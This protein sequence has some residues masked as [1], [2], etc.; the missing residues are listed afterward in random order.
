MSEKL[1]QAIQATRV[2]DKKN[3]QFLLTQAIQEEPDNPQSWYL[4]SLLVDDNEKQQVYLTKVLDLD[5]DHIKAHEKL[6]AISQTAVIKPALIP[7]T[8]E[9]EEE[10]IEIAPVI[11]SSNSGDLE[12]QDDGETL[13]DWMADDLPDLA[14]KTTTTVVETAVISET[15]VPDWLQ[16][17]VDETWAENETETAVAETNQPEIK[18]APKPAEENKL[19]I[20]EKKTA[21]AKKSGEKGLN[22][23]LIGLVVIAIIVFM[24]LAY[25]I[26]TMI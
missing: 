23:L 22:Y 19:A 13:P 25:F 4:L 8:E 9:I 26:L 2:G 10:E 24:I 11:L 20:A 12:A 5:P 17:S 7:F 6:V 21:P 18:D 15:V 16:G 3:A 14:D 1:Q